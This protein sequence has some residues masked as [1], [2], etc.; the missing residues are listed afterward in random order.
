[1]G[2]PPLPL[3][4]SGKVLSATLPNGR[5]TARVKLRDHDGRV[6]LVSMVVRRGRQPSGR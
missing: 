1:V 6:R 4:T 5:V 2:R 3:N